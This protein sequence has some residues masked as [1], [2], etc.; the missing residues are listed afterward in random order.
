MADKRVAIIGR[1]N[2]GKSTLFNRLAGK[3]LALVH[4]LPGV[5]R[6]RREAPASLADLRFT[7]I[8]TAGLDD[9]EKGSLTERMRAQ[10]LAA[11]DHADAILFMVDAKAGLLGPDREFGQLLRRRGRKVIL[12]ANKAE[13]R[14]ADSDT[15]FAL[16]LGDP[17]PLSA[18]HGEGL[19]ELYNALAPLVRGSEDDRDDSPSSARAKRRAREARE[20]RPE[21]GEEHGDDGDHPKADPDK[22]LQLAVVGRPNVGKS[23]LVNQ[24]LGTD[25]MLTGPEAGITRDAIAIDWDYR[26]RKIRLFDTAGMRRRPRVTEKLEFLAVSDAREA[27]RFAEV[28]V[29]VVDATQMLEK[30]D[31]TIA[32]EIAEEGR[33]VVLA[34]NKWDLVADKREKLKDMHETLETGVAQLAGIATVTLSAKSGAGIDKL[35]PAVLGAYEV[36]NRRVP[37]PQLNR[38]LEEAQSRNPPPLVSGRRLRL[39]YMT[40][41]NIRPPTFALFASKPGDLPDSYRRYLVNMLRDSFD[42]PGVPIRMMLRKGKNPYD[43]KR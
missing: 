11:L 26:G 36:W 2:V 32:R 41:A 19:G 6:D 22:P 20:S 3:K 31:L 43:D 10:T 8:D 33:A 27:I 39:R 13:G 34:V 14:N 21:P 42:L 18:E 5:T 24:L 16:G 7:V 1:P 25:R 30:Q 9:G 29:L 17:I 35:M 28:C 23:T 12:V 38:W 15:F 37:T 40:Q 4:D